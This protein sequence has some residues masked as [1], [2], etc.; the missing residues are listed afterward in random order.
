MSTTRLKVLYIA[1]L[2]RSGSTLLG[3][4]LGEVEGFFFVGEISIIW[5]YFLREDRLCG[6]GVPASECEVWRA[7]LTQALDGRED[8]DAQSMD[9]FC[10]PRLLRHRVAGMLM[11]LMPAGKRQLRSRWD[12][13]LDDLR[14]LYFS[15]RS[16][17]GCRVIVD[18]SKRPQ[19]AY[20]LG[21]IPEID[22]Y[23]LHLVRDPRG[24]A[25]SW[26]RKKVQQIVGDET[27]Y[28]T[29][30]G[31]VTTAV[32]WLFRNAMVELFWRR[33][34]GRYLLLRYEDLINQ[35]R[36]AI[37]RILDL[38]HDQ[39][40]DLP[41]ASERVVNLGINHSVRGNPSRFDTGPVELR[42]DEAWKEKMKRS[43]KNVVTA[44]T[45]PL[46]KRYGYRR[47]G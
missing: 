20:R 1:G 47:D 32:R 11:M 8:V 46:L 45:W 17:T 29:E 5:K 16:G 44:L 34:P 15:I 39:P 3:N 41:L 25:Y 30:Y 23:V 24:V 43:D 12:R 2:G 4:I 31:L 19:Y 9:Q 40:A 13:P 14:R 28:M 33:T 37:Q 27:L 6:C 26:R 38:M 10:H 7:V 21:L 22:L 18:S 36:T 42:L 35:P